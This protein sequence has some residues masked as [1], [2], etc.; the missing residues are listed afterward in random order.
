M[1]ADCTIGMRP[2]V[3]MQC[4]ANIQARVDYKH[5]R[6]WLAF[7]QVAVARVKKWTARHR[8]WV[9]HSGTGPGRFYFL[10]F[11]AQHWP[12][13]FWAEP[14]INRRLKVKKGLPKA[15][16]TDW[17][18]S[19]PRN[20]ITRRQV[21]KDQNRKIKSA[22]NFSPDRSTWIR[23]RGKKRDRKA[24]EVWNS[25]RFIEHQVHAK[26]SNWPLRAKMLKK[27]S[28]SSRIRI[29]KSGTKPKSL[30]IQI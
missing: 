22:T 25:K 16:C 14:L 19:A 17:L 20:A 29:G 3:T 13:D 23:R 12:D 2:T 28:F 27:Q 4:V 1:K 30:I 8:F 11:L 15:A 7:L 6:F 21:R 10:V 18:I 5:V 9:L 24:G 26:Q